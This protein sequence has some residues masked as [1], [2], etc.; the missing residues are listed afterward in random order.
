MTNDLRVAATYAT[1]AAGLATLP[2][3]WRASGQASWVLVWVGAWGLAAWL[4]GVLAY[5]WR[6]L[7]R[8]GRSPRALLVAVGIST[9]LIILF[10]GLLHRVTHHRP[11]GAATFSV[12]AGLIFLLTLA[13]V[14]RLLQFSQAGGRAAQ[15]ARLALRLALG[16]GCLGTLAAVGAAL[17]LPSPLAHGLLDGLLLALAIVAAAALPPAKWSNQQSLSLVVWGG[18]GVS[19]AGVLWLC[20]SCLAAL[21]HSAPVVA[22]LGGWL[23]G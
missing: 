12:L 9:P 16:V 14:A 17:Q 15:A 3:A 1:I 2:A 18:L 13:L 20:P 10:A 19:S 4:V 11:L 7:L 21:R 22:S 5:S 6:T 8:S 23:G